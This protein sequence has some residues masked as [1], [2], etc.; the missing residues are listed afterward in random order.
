MRKPYLLIALLCLG[1]FGWHGGVMGQTTLGSNI[2]NPSLSVSL[3]SLPT[4]LV[5]PLGSDTTVQ[6]MATVS[7]GASPYFYSWGPST[8]NYSFPSSDSSQPA[9]TII[10]DNASL[11]FSVTVTDSLGCKFTTTTSG[12]VI[13]NTEEAIEN[14]IALQVY[15]N[16]NQGVFHISLEGI[17]TSA[18]LFL[19][20]KDQLGR[21]VYRESLPRFTGSL[22]KDLNL[23]DLSKGVY[24]LGIGLEGQAVFNKLIIE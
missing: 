16:L 15:P 1:V 13:I 19:T 22:E 17:P 10:S 5:I 4:P 11:T 2:P 24:F 7:G 6:M 18:P 9:L 20:V 23:S 14:L 12:N 8:A 21:E 3:N